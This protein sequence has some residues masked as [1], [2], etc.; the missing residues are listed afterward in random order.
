MPKSTELVDVV[1]A[2]ERF[3]EDVLGIVTPLDPGAWDV[4]LRATNLINHYPNL[5]FK[6]QHGFP[7]A[8][9]LPIETTDILSNH[10]SATVHFDAIVQDIM[11]EVALGRVAGP[12]STAALEHLVGPFRTCPLGV[13]PK[14][15]S[16]GK[17][18]IVRDLSAK[19]GRSQSVNDEIDSDEWPTRWDGA[20]VI[21]SYASFQ[22]TLAPLNR[23]SHIAHRTPHIALIAHRTSLNAKR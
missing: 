3:Q 20:K 2:P 11:S 9:L 22:F 16:T 7:I 1:A 13:I 17:F 21:A 8:D 19:G 15:G 4:I 6:I 18:R 12:F 14:S 10:S 23:T 5:P